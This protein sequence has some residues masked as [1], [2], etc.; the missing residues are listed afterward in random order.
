VTIDGRA[1][2]RWYLTDRLE[3]AVWNHALIG[4]VASAVDRKLGEAFDEKMKSQVKQHR[5]SET[6]IW[7][8]AY[9]ADQSVTEDALQQFTAGMRA[10]AAATGEIF[11]DPEAF[12]DE[13]LS[14]VV[15]SAL[16]SLRCEQSRILRPVDRP[17]SLAWSLDV[18]PWYASYGDGAGDWPPAGATGMQGNESLRLSALGE[19]QRGRFAGWRQVALAERQHTPEHRYPYAP[20][21]TVT[22]LIGLCGSG[23][24]ISPGDL[25]FAEN[26]WFVWTK[27][28]GC[29]QAEMDDADRA[30]HYPRA[31]F[32]GCSGPT[33]EGW[34]GQ[35]GLELP[36]WMIGPRNCLKDL[37]ELRVT[38]GLSGLSLSDS[39]G[40]AIVARHWRSR[41]VHDGAFRPFVH[42]VEGTDVL[43]RLDVL[44]TLTS[45]VGDVESQQWIGLESD[46]PPL[47]ER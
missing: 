13:L 28:I 24:D 18:A 1:L 21:R 22:I 29:S 12:E 11:D 43:M 34:R 44:D 7:P 32:F 23:P 47:D 9:F 14:A 30:I 15:D 42:A 31:P 3:A 19:I 5:R 40:P 36:H 38:K 27:D 35:P 26:D 2:V 41:P 16:L 33:S 10:A 4:A 37:L 46:E 20:A 45:I 6:G 8:D 25:P 17:A 39:S